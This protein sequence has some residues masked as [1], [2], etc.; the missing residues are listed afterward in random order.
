MPDIDDRPNAIVPLRFPFTHDGIDYTSL[1]V[2]RP[3]MRD[4]LAL[5]A[6]GSDEIR[7]AVRLMALLCNVSDSVI[8]ELD[9]VD[10]GAVQEQYAAFTGR[11]SEKK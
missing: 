2:R 4:T 9:E 7:R 10:V 8:E 3:K 5:V 11:S 6:F 1:T